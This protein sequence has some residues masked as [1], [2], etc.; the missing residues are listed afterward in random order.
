MQ[1]RVIEKSPSWRW[2]NIS[3]LWEYRE[4]L[5][6]LTMRDI[7]IKY[8]QTGVGI[9]WA[10]INPIVSLLILSFVFGV[11]AKVQ[12][13]G[14]PHAIFTIAGLAGWN[15]FG[16]V[17]QEGG[18]SIITAQ[19]MVSKIYF[20]RLIIPLTKVLSSLIDLIVTLICLFVLM[21]YY[22]FMPSTNVIYLPI[23]LLMVILA[24]AT[25]AIWMSALTIR[26]RD[27]QYVT[28]FI[29]RIGM[30]I[31]PIAYPLSMV[32]ERFQSIYSLNPMVGVI[33][34]LRWSLI[35]GELQV[36]KVLISLVSIVFFL[37]TGLLLF[38]NVERV[39]AD[40]V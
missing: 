34:G 38:R 24:G 30:Y 27:F 18:T 19:N 16:N 11:V 36:D 17:M 20:P 3:E 35:G 6:V 2:V 4:L 28:P 31:T 39:I 29:V 9:A 10:L 23:F 15:Y 14:V 26:F 7:R 12:V 37:V 13:P 21:L 1:V 32:P 22:Q 25:G 33:E 8:A 5:G 40:I